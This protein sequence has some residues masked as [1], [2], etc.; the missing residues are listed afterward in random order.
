[1]TYCVPVW[2]SSQTPQHP[3]S[4]EE[5][6]IEMPSFSSSFFSERVVLP[7]RRVSRTLGRGRFLT[8]FSALYKFRIN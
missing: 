2:V 7:D 6:A 1:M 4:G 8:V 5:R 3:P